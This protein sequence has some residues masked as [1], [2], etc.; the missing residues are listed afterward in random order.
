[1]RKRSLLGTILMVCGT[2]FVCMPI[3]AAS[4]AATNSLTIRNCGRCGQNSGITRE[5]FAADVLS[6]P[7]KPDYV[8]IYIGM[9]DVINDRF[10]T[11]LDAYLENVTEMIAQSR[12]AGVS[13]VICTIHHVIEAEVY[14]HHSRDKFGA[15]TVNGKMDRYNAALRKLAAEQR[16]ALADFNAVTER[17]RPS[18]FLSEDGVHLALA[19]NRLLAKTFFDV[20]APR[21]RGQETIVCVGDSLTYGYRNKGAGTC[22]GETYPAMLRTFAINASV[23]TV[24][25]R[26]PATYYLAEQGDDANEGTSSGKAWKTIDRINKTQL[27]PGDTVLL[28]GGK[29]FAGNLFIT[30][31]GNAKAFISISSYGKGTA[32]IRAGD[33]YAIRLLNCQYIKVSNLNLLGSGV[34]PT[35]ETTNKE[36]GLDIYSTAKEGSPWQSIYV[37]TLTV[38]GFH[39]GIVLHTPIGTQDVVGYNDVRISNC[40]VKECL[41][42]GIYCWGSKRTTG[43]PWGLPAGAGVFT[44]CTLGGCTIH[45]IYGDPEG[46][47]VICLPSQIFN[48][49]SFLVERCTIYDCGQAAKDLSQPGGVGGLVF[50]ECEKSVAQF[51]ECYRIVTKLKMDGCAFDI[52]GGCSNCILQ[53]NYSHDNEGSGFQTG[54]MIGGGPVRDNIIRYNI[55]QNDAKKNPGASGGI[56]TWGVQSG[57][58]YNNTVFVSAGI[59]GTKPAALLGNTFGGANGVTVM[60]NIFVVN[61]DGDI[62]YSNARSTFRNNCYYRVKGDF[63]VTYA[64]KGYTTLAAWQDATGQEKLNN[65][66]VGFSVNPQFRAPGRAGAINDASKLGTL[67]AYDLSP[68]SPL[69]DKGLNMQALFGIA[70]APSD[71]R[72]TPLRTGGTCDL[73]AVEHK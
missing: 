58:V 46:N 52:D 29:S 44:H 17:L 28:E 56:M 33:S 57:Y 64:G 22:E 38:S 37:D 10:F 70:T 63:R 69:L 60:N 8:L 66:P 30:A 55:S 23:V 42:G 65:V 9:N 13:P 47:P 15:E 12:K 20:I 39:D 5:K 11:P 67:N 61:H 50:L 31:S 72:G 1:M 49:T 3:T 4:L 35:G 32:S 21:L 19:G 27:C 45:D 53:Y 16:V 2:S 59:G 6:L 62:V 51:N 7:P 34:T 71:F 40:T 24:E 18:D 73:G 14:K 41:V 36:Q 68:S 54:F 43:K 48:A 26:T 25:A